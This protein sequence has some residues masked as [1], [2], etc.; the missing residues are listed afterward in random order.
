MRSRYSAYAR[1]EIAFITDSLHPSSRHDHDPA[2]AQRW[3]E[4]SEWLGLEVVSVDGGSREDERGTVEFIASYR[5]KGAMRTHHEV[6]QFVKEQGRW[7]FQDGKQV[8]PKTVQRE[9]AKVGRNDPCPCGSGRKY[10]KCC[11]K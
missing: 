8:P 6:A 3:A 1:S 11:G 4:Q 9:G 10:K 7:F 2:A 5:E